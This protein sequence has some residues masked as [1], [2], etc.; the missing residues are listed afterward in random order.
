MQTLFVQGALQGT[1]PA[2]AFFVNCDSTTTTQADVDNGVM[3]ILI[4]MAPIRPAEFVII[5][6][7]QIFPP[8]S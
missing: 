5:R 2:Q 3:N 8:A 1:T 6:I 4:G 7:Q